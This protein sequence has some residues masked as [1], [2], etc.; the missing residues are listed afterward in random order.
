MFIA[1]SFL[2]SWSLGV[3]ACEPLSWSLWS[4]DQSLLMDSLME[5]IGLMHR[6]Y[7]NQKSVPGEGIVNL[8]KS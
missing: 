7:F 5:T 1:L 4:E 6:E 8:V 2:R 3:Q